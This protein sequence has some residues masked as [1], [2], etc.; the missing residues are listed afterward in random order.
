[1]SLRRIIAG[2]R[3]ALGVKYASRGRDDGAEDDK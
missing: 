3:L 2:S 1:M